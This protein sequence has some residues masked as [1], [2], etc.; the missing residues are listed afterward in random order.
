MPGTL[1]IDFTKVKRKIRSVPGSPKQS[2]TS[3]SISRGAGGLLMIQRGWG[4]S[5][6]GKL[7]IKKTSVSA[8]ST[9]LVHS[10]LDLRQ[11]SD[12][13]SG[14]AGDPA[15]TV[16]RRASAEDLGHLTNAEDLL[17]L[18]SSNGSCGAGAKVSVI[19]NDQQ[20]L[21]VR[22]FFVWSFCHLYTLLVSQQSLAT[23]S[24]GLKN[25]WVEKFKGKKNFGSKIFVS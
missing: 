18:Q 1:D 25:F 8:T 17:N 7:K 10:R 11:I 21:L 19:L 2:P 20:L 3:S 6:F 13:S 14:P 9:P 22:T 12:D 23:D 24:F 5:G 15:G 4:K 16:A